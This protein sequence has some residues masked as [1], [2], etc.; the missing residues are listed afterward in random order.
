MEGSPACHRVYTE[1]EKLIND[2]TVILSPCHIR[3]LERAINLIIVGSYSDAAEL[4]EQVR[5]G[6]I[7]PVVMQDTTSQPAMTRK[8]LKRFLHSVAC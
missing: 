2:E 7:D 8:A 6:Q 1:C 4:I 5:K 3:V